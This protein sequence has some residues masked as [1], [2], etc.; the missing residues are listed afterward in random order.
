MCLKSLNGLLI[1]AAASSASR[2]DEQA[3]LARRAARGTHTP[4]DEAYEQDQALENELLALLDELEQ[5][6][7]V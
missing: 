5:G 4:T 6:A 3:Y 2:H 7:S 1:S